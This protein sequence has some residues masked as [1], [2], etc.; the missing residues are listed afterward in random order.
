[1]SLQVEFTLGSSATHQS[2]AHTWTVPN[3]YLFRFTATACQGRIQ[4]REGSAG[5][6][7]PYE[8]LSRFLLT[9]GTHSAGVLILITTYL[10]ITYGLLTNLLS[11]LGLQTLRAGTVFAGFR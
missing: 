6:G 11:P 1:M 3:L 7:E 5:P 2:N 9:G 8:R 4:R 10:L